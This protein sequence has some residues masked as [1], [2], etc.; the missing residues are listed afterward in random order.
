MT[1]L[2]LLAGAL[3]ALAAVSPETAHSQDAP[4]PRPAD[5][6]AIGPPVRRIATAS[7]LSTENL[8]SI[9]SVVELRDGRVLVNDGARRRLLLMDTTLT[10]VEVILDSLSEIANTYG[11]RPGALVPYRGDTTLF[12][13]PA[14]FAMV[15]LD[16]AGRVAR[17][18]SVWRVQDVFYYTTPTGYGFPG[19]DAKGRVVYRMYAQPTPPKVAPP[20]G[21]PYIPQDPDSAFVVA[22]D[23]DT[24]K[25][26]TIA[27]FRIPKTDYTIRQTAEGYISIF[28]KLNPLPSTDEWAV[29]PNGDVAVVRGRDYRVEYL[30]ADGTRTSGPK[31][32]FDWQRLMDV[33]KQR[34]VDSVKSANQR[35][36]M[37]SYLMQII[38]W[39]N[40]YNR[41]Y[42]PNLTIPQGTTIP[43]GLFK[44]WKLPPGM[45]FPERYIFACAAG[46]EPKMI[47]PAGGAT[48][49]PVASVPVGPPGAPP[50]QVGTPSC[51]PTPISLAG[52]NAP[53][54]PT[55]REVGVIAPNDLPDYRPPFTAGAVRA[56][57]DGNLW[58]RT[59]PPKPVPGGIIFDV[60]NATGELA[61]RIQLP[62]GYT[63]VGFGRGKVV[64]LS[65]RDAKGIH[66]AR[67]RLR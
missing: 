39:T 49:A 18:R 52:G 57:A 13:D 19:T 10:K 26:D 27:S 30:H 2:D 54:A 4:V 6:P 50:P 62:S 9:A 29:L 17:V 53:P 63:L 37:S 8:G 22:I 31:L 40:M 47:A 44:E 7:A 23:I 58:I 67:V 51:I 41:P 25:L 55:M 11:Q 42:P 59:I 34:L 1:K 32:P 35:Q 3:F 33:D 12:I 20:P 45:Q 61:D 43:T 14:S 48:A 15:V 38:R 36:V 56:D 28:M 46:E 64:Y 21:V 66:L 60:V 16:P 65:M 24:R 5:A